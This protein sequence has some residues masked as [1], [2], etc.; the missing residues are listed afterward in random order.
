[1]TAPFLSPRT[2]RARSVL[3][4]FSRMTNVLIAL[5]CVVFVVGPASGLNGIYGT[6]DAVVQAQTAYFERWGVIPRELWSGSPGPLLT[7]LTALFVHGSWLHLLGNVLFLYVFGGMA[8]DRMGRLPF[9]LFYLVTGYLALMGYA[10]AHA[11]SGQTLVGASGAISGVL[12][13]FLYLFPKAR[14]TSIYPFLFFLPLRFPAWI[15]LLFWFVLQWIAAQRDPSTPGVAYLAHVV[16]FAVGFLYA[17]VRYRPS[18]APP[19]ETAAATGRVDSAGTAKQ[20][21]A[22][23]ESQP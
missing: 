19:G 15:V 8:E 13:A 10:A 12:G 6:G 9:T 5:C 4:V 23:G 11:S 21:A 14:V 3:T 1:M 22:E 2:P 17:W 18:P 16:G 7:P 20:Q